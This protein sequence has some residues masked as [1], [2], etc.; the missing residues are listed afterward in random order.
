MMCDDMI[1]CD[2]ICVLICDDMVVRCDDLEDLEVRE[3]LLVLEDLVDLDDLND[4]KGF[5]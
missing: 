1:W 4:L 2:V 3:D 5:D